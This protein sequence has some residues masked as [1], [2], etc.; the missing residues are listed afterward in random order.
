[1]SNLNLTRATLVVAAA[2][3]VLPACATKK[4][5]VE[6][7]TKLD[8]MTA[9]LDQLLE[10]TRRDTLTQVFGEQTEEIVAKIDALDPAQRQ[11]FETLIGE[12]QKGQTTL[13]EVRASL[14]TMMGGGER[15]VSTGSGIWVRGAD[16][17]KLKAI[18]RGT[19]LQD[20]RKLE[21]TE[22]PAPIA[23]K[24]GLAQ[25]TWGTGTLDG[26]TV[27]FPW[28]FTMSSFA[29]EIVENTA[30]RT[31]EEM[32]RMAGDGDFNRPINIQVTTDPTGEGLKITY[33]TEEGEIYLSTSPKPAG[34]ASPAPNAPAEKK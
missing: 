33:P 24:P 20:C 12:F 17:E 34:P 29:K 15:E 27:V 10:N 2:L 5:M 9:Q 6:T 1:M 11:Q 30:R 23:A 19:E 25:M 26:Q 31:A 21:D 7:N 16:G 18:S 4:Q 14:I 3:T 32:R 28:D 22:L 8:H 13:E